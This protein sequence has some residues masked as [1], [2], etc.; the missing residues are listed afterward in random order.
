MN[1]ERTRLCLCHREVFTTNGTYQMSFVT[2]IFRND[3]PGHGDESKIF[4]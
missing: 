2:Q 4:K 3:E 1:K